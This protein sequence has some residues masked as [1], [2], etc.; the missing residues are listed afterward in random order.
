MEQT[1]RQLE[2]RTSEGERRNCFAVLYREEESVRGINDLDPPCRER[3]KCTGVE[4]RRG[5]RV[6][7]TITVVRVRTETARMVSFQGGRALK[8]GKRNTDRNADS[9]SKIVTGA[10]SRG[11]QGDRKG[12][13]RGGK[14]C[15]DVGNA[16]RCGTQARKIKIGLGAWMQEEAI[17]SVEIM[18]GDSTISSWQSPNLGYGKKRRDG[19]ESLDHDPISTLAQH[20]RHHRGGKTVGPLPQLR[21][22]SA[23]KG[24]SSSRTKKRV[25]IP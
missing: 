1:G 21:Q 10:R 11:G 9:R 18:S 6:G 17:G 3:E 13:A 8:R 5:E 23:M 16:K 7:G 4:G 25:G 20:V 22:R 14:S 2:G 12:E 15:W 24:I 19:R